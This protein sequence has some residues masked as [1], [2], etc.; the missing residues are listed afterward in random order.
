M[1]SVPIK[2]KGG[3]EAGGACEYGGVFEL[4]A[5]CGKRG[6]VPRKLFKDFL[7]GKKKEQKNLV[8]PPS[9][10]FLSKTYQTPPLLPIR[11]RRRGKKGKCTG[12][13]DLSFPLHLSPFPTPLLLQFLRFSKCPHRKLYICGALKS[14]WLMYDT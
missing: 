1:L 5:S 2:I 11:Y 7:L 4:M 12:G 8:F 14:V 9:I 6:E 10:F 13:T 3:R